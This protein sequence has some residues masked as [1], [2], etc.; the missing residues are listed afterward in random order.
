MYG[1]RDEELYWKQKSRAN[2]LQECDLNT[3]FFHATTKQRRARNR[4][5][6]LR[7][8]NGVWEETQ[9]DIEEVATRYFQ[10]LFTSLDPSDFDDSLKYITEKVTPAMND[11]FTKLP[12]DD[13]IRK[14]V[15]DISPDKAPS[16]D[17]MTSLFFQ[18]YWGITAAVMRQ[19]VIDFFQDNALDP[20]L[21][22]T[23]ICLIPKTD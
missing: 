10:T 21:N 3:K 17:G 9:N 23:N 19:T 2:W 4:V 22:Q 5:T 1:F 16:P 6:K 11:A 20:R 7:K 14:A 13:E 18:K 15:F 12:S 8:S